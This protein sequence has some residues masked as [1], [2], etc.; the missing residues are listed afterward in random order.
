MNPTFPGEIKIL[1]QRCGSLDE[2]RAE[3]ERSLEEKVKELEECQLN[4]VQN[5]ARLKSQQDYG[6]EL[7][8]RKRKLDEEMDALREE[9]ARVK[10]KESVVADA[11]KTSD[12]VSNVSE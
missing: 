1:T 5:E 11:G 7:E 2:Q 3:T 4:L 10:A 12:E 6:K 8:G 9:L